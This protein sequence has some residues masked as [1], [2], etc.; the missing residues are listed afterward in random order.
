MKIRELIEE[1]DRKAGRAKLASELGLHPNRLTDWK[2]GRRKPEPDEI[3]VLAKAAGLP[4]A[5][6]VLGVEAE[7]Y[8]RHGALLKDAVGKLKA[9]GVAAVLILAIL[10]HQEAKAGA[11]QLG[12]MH[13]LR[14]AECQYAP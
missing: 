12:N 6:T 9:A 13:T 5:E 4:V 11:L 1:A 10:P 7:M 3:A 14:N 8:P 2:A